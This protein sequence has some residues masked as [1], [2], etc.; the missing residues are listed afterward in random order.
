MCLNYVCEICGEQKN[1]L[2]NAYVRDIMPVTHIILC[3]KRMFICEEC[4]K[5]QDD[6][7]DFIEKMNKGEL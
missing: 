4:A 3:E 5:E 2:L 7:L 1:G 6:M